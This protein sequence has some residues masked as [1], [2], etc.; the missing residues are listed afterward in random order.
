MNNMYTAYTQTYMN[1][2]NKKI[3]TKTLKYQNLS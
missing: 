1:E 3:K 2:M